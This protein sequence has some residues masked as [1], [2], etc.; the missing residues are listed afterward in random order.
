[1][2]HNLFLI[3][4]EPLCERKP[5]IR[6]GVCSISFS[7][8]LQQNMEHTFYREKH[9]L[10]I[11]PGSVAS[12]RCYS[13]NS[14]QGHGALSMWRAT[15]LNGSVSS[16]SSRPCPCWQTNHSI[17]VCYQSSTLSSRHDSKSSIRSRKE[18]TLQKIG[19][20]LQSS[21]TLLG[22]KGQFPAQQLLFLNLSERDREK[23]SPMFLCRIIVYHK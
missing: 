20:F 16:F 10:E 2:F 8:W 9:H 18:G 6:V 14:N 5:W 11:K 13:N 3:E 15:V 23:S 17:V 12:F 4:C 19:E 7:N 22:T 1:M 21:P